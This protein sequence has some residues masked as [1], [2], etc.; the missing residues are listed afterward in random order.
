[1]S[2]KIIYGCQQNLISPDKELAAVLEFICSESNKLTNS[3][4]YYARQLFFKTKKIVGKYDLEAEYKSNPHFQALHS[5]AAQQILRSVAESFKSF[6]E[7]SK[8]FRSWELKSK[9]KPPKYRKP[10]GLA[11]VTYPKQALKL[12]DGLIRIPLGNTVKRWFKLDSFTLIMP[13]NLKFEDIKELRIVPRN[14]CFYV[15]F[16]YEQK[17]I[18][19]VKLDPSKVLGIDH[20]VG[21]WLTIVSNVGTSFIID[22][23]KL[24]SVNQWYNKQIATIKEG[25]PQGFWSNKL[26]AITEKRNRQMR[27]AVNKTARIVINHCLIN[28]IGTVVFG[29]NEGQK[30]SSNMGKKNNQK[31][32]QIPTGKLKTRIAQLCEQYEIQFVETEESYTSRSSFLDNDVLPKYGEKPDG[33]QSSGKRIVRGLFKTGKKLLIN[34]DCNGA[35]NIVRK[36]SATLGLD[37]DGVSRGALSTP[38][39]VHFWTP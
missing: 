31:F 36:V 19:V 10:K 6:K 15:E 5:Q 24:Q 27:D 38:L 3:G 28:K 14:R 17:P 2:E 20:G 35:A 16:V 39:R 8:L 12:I 37:L 21:N 26:A 30:D 34:A 22:G 25:K 9:P 33:W 1:M 13:S 32:V 29:W 23:L 18:N 4:I 11:L 7:L